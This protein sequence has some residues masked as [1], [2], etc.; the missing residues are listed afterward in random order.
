MRRLFRLALTGIAAVFFGLAIFTA[1]TVAD[2]VGYTDWIRSLVRD[3]WSAMI[4]A[5]YASWIQAGALFFG[6]AVFPDGDTGRCTWCFWLGR[7][8]A[9]PH[10]H[11]RTVEAGKKALTKEWRGFLGRAGLAVAA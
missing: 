2:A 9:P 11:A 6:G 8:A 1:E 5:G 10:K 3:G 7:G 4:D